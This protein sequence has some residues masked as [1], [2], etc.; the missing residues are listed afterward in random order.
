MS[1]LARDGDG[2]ALNPARHYA[3]AFRLLADSRAV[4][5]KYNLHPRLAILGPLEARLL[6]FDLVILGG[7]NEGKWP[8]QTATDPWLSRPMRRALGLESPERRIGLS[9]HDF[10]S[11]AASRRVLLTRSKKEN[12]SPAVASRWLLRLQQLATGM[13]AQEILGARADILSWARQL[14]DGPRV[15]RATRPAPAPPAIDTATLAFGHRSGDLDSRPL[16]DLCK[17]CSAPETAQSDSNRKPGPQNAAAPFTA[18][19]KNS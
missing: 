12:G 10:A 4:R 5:P 14:D 8:A 9:A 2:V 3:D 13:G 19:W 16:R 6:D 17:A 7:L 1:E 15:T 18:H 11:L